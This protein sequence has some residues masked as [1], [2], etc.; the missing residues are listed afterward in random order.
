M[1]DQNGNEFDTVQIGFQTWSCQNLNVDKFR[2]GDPIHHA[3]SENE[4][5]NASRNKQP[6]WCYFDN[7]PGNGNKHGKL[8]NWYAVNDAR[9]LAP[10][11]WRVPTDDDWHQFVN[12]FGGFPTNIK[13]IKK[14]NK[15]N[16]LLSGV[17]S[18]NEWG[19][20][21]GG[22]F[23]Y[24]IGNHGGWWASNN[25]SQSEGIMFDLNCIASSENTFRISK[26]SGYSVRCLKD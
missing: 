4:W 5:V 14:N 7:D 21:S 22:F 24:G 19:E 17:R 10:E 20:L 26:G 8:Y 25:Y 9:G 23:L 1:V 11:G 18:D 16:V 12:N 13:K 6:A 15:W 3:K 2:N